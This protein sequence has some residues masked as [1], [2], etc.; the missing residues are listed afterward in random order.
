MRTTPSGNRVHI[1]IFGKCNSGKSTLMNA[2]TGQHTAVVSEIAGTTTDPVTKSMEIS[3]IGPCLL[4]DTPGFDDIGILSKERLQKTEAIKRQTDIALIVCND[5]DIDDEVQLERFFHSKEVPI[6]PVINS[7][8]EEAYKRELYIHIYHE[9]GQ[10]PVIVNAKE[11]SGIS[12]LLEEISKFA[13]LK[14]K[15]SITGNLVDRGDTVLL[16]MPQD[17]QAPAGRLILPQAQTIRELLDKHCMVVCCTPDELEICLMNINSPPKL[18]ITDS[19]VVNE[20]VRLKPPASKLTTFSILFAGQKGDINILV[21]GAEAINTLT[22]HSRVLIAEACTHAPLEEDIG[23]VKIPR[24]LRNRVG[25]NLQIDVVSG[26]DFPDDLTPYH[27]I[28]HCGACMFNPRLLHSRLD[29]ANSLQ[30]PITNYGIAIAFM[31][32][33]LHQMAY[34]TKTIASTLEHNRLSV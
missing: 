21:E 23:R 30:V 3:G 13:Y 20:V 27:L 1:A 16:V 18:I 10:V 2:I 19:Q 32:G 17:R 11:G 5:M 24:M 8:K 26:A 12:V 29:K 15:K 14:E 9:T 31:N 33:I 7:D 6:I 25:K 4:I 22:V 34:P 28:I